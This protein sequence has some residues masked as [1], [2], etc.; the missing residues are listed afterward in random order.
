MTSLSANSCIR[1]CEDP[2]RSLTKEP[3]HCFVCNKDKISLSENDNWSVESTHTLLPLLE[4]AFSIKFPT[5]N[6][7]D[8]LFFC[9]E[10]YKTWNELS[11]GWEKMKRIKQF[12][13]TL[14][15]K[16]AAK[17]YESILESQL[18]QF[19]PCDDLFLYLRTEIFFRKRL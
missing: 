14:R 1:K 5:L 12:N 8:D 9:F 15:K 19:E 2:N 6:R 17:I 11:I 18:L 3:I 7:D 10:C 16:L 4:K 13:N